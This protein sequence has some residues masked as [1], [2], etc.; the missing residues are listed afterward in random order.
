LT[1]FV[2]GER[3]AAVL[4]AIAI[5][6]GSAS[7]SSAATA[8]GKDF[9]GISAPELYSMSVDGRSALRDAALEQIQAAGIDT[10]RTE[11]GWRDL[12]PTAPVGGVHAYNWAQLYP[13]IAALAE[14]GQRLAPMIMAPPAWAQPASSAGA[15]QRRGGIDPSH[16]G[17]YAAFTAEV[18][19]IFGRNG[20]YWQ[21][22]TA[23]RPEMPQRPITSY[24]I[25]NEPN[26]DY[27]WCPDIDPE[28]YAVALGKAADAIHAVD[29]RAT[30]SAGGLVVLEADQYEGAHLTGMATETFLRRMVAAVPDLASRIDAVAVHTYW[31]T[32]AD[33]LR[34]L[35]LVDNWLDRVGLGNESL[36]VSEYGWR[37]GGPA[38][39]VSEAQ[40]ALMIRDYSDSLARTDCNVIGIYPHSWI[41]PRLDPANP[42]HWFGLAD[43]QTGAPLAA[44]VAYAGVVDSY[45]HG[46]ASQQPT[47]DVC[48]GDT[49]G[50]EV[51]LSRSNRHARPVT[52]VVDATDPG[53]VVKMQYRLDDGDWRPT[54][55]TI[56]IKRSGN[57]KHTLR[58]RAFDSS[59]NVSAVSRL[60][61]RLHAR[62][63]P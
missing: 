20:T 58:A 60:R 3:S 53:G 37:S 38:G 47:L 14:H 28:T 62:H 31:A 54:K 42:E 56:R 25:F 15:C 46:S 63:R 39:A 11:L 35:S 17:D 21:W 59:G 43:P 23:N 26:W 10:V 1:R 16:V 40:R 34:A 29:P 12:E 51:N 9:F 6:G 22:A 45:E 52:F 61:W 19:R 48:A 57:A 41:T 55:G 4:A 5:L 30:V 33:D 24:E 49:A 32:P 2:W 8:P 36:I 18:A 13:H 44:G 27:F 7:Q 50:P